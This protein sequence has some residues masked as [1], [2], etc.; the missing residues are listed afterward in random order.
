[1][2]IIEKTTM[3]RF[4]FM[5][6]A[7]LA[8]IQAG[9]VELE[10]EAEPVNKAP[11]KKTEAQKAARRMAID[12]QVA[13]VNV[14][15]GDG[16]GDFDL[17]GFLNDMPDAATPKAPPKKPAA[18]QGPISKKTAVDNII[19][20]AGAAQVDAEPAPATGAKLTDAEAAKLEA[21][22]GAATTMA[23]KTMILAKAKK[24]ATKKK[25]RRRGNM[26]DAMRIMEENEAKAAAGGTTLAQGA[27]GA[28]GGGGSK[29]PGTANGGGGGAGMGGR[30]D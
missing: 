1:M 11:A 18:K 27:G 28:R 26:H 5:V 20:L 4:A 2:G 23:D 16:D 6:V 12:R 7:A 19:G 8:A 13:A 29:R 10:L 3:R 21:K 22:V 9:A 25:R 15:D 24:D 14:N 17:E 30:T